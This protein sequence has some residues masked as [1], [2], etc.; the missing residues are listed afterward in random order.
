M[1]EERRE[2][3]AARSNAGNTH[4]AGEMFVAA[5]LAKRG[6]SV[7]LT[8]GNA[9]AV[10]LFAE[11]NG[12]AICIQVK[13]IAHKRNVGW[14]LP[15]NK[16]KIIDKVLYVCV[17][18]NEVGE[19]PTYYVLPPHEVRERGRWYTNRAILDIGRLRGSGFEGAWHLIDA[20]LRQAD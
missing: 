12:N 4:I 13:A 19:A 1:T 8:M 9:K 15:F 18:L 7:S 6:Y 14:P 10:D 2:V 17:I 5:E 20:A 11:R 16:A 3:S